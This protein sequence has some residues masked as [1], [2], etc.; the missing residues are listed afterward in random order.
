MAVTVAVATEAETIGSSI[1]AVESDPPRVVVL[2]ASNVA[3]GMRTIVK[4]A[5]EQFQS[6]IDFY[7]SYSHGR[8]YG[9][10][11]SVGWWSY[12]SILQSG[13]WNA[14]HANGTQDLKTVALITDV[15]N[16]ILYG[17]SPELIANWIRD[18][19]GRL[20]QIHA[21]VVLT[22]LPIASVETLGAVRFQLMKAI[23]FP[24]CLFNLEEVLVRARR[25]NES[26]KK[27]ANEMQVGMVCPDDAWYGVDPI[28]IR[29]RMMT[30]AWRSYLQPL[31]THVCSVEHAIEPL[32]QEL[33]L[34]PSPARW[35]TFGR[36]RTASQPSRTL[37]DGSQLHRF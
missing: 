22:E 37:F 6:P 20:Q 15:G 10:R 2:G 14:L 21:R 1:S 29:R 35:N 32:K 8:S 27:I 23:L 18:V 5:R 34:H 28:H 25:L 19:V 30:D 16:D 3:R 31:A 24:K 36:E 7:F 9:I 13:I 17:A 11:S 26:L 12:P 4:V 33:F